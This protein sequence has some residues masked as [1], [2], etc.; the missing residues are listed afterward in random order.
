MTEL[1]NV[2]CQLGIA[3]LRGAAVSLCFA[4]LP[5]VVLADAAEDFYISTI[6]SIV[7]SQCIVC[8]V[9]GG[10]ADAG[11]ADILFTNDAS[12]NHVAF[13]GYVNTPTEGA[14]ADRVLSKITGGSGHG[15]GAVL[16]QASSSYEAIAEYL[17]LLVQGDDPAV[18][19]VLRVFL[20]EPVS[21]EIHAGV[22]NLRGWAVATDGISR[23][24]ILVDG[25]YAFDA[26]Y[27]GARGDV[28]GAFPD[29]EN[30][31][32]S[33]FALAYAYSLLTAGPHTI[34]AVAHTTLGETLESSADFE[35]VKFASDF[36]AD[37]EAVDFSSG[38][39]SLSPREI[40]I[41][42][43]TVEGSLYDVVLKW[44]T[45]AQGFE[46]IEIRP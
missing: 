3:R 43:A 46:F 45:A 5:D 36:I 34:T 19:K 9:A 10:Q 31:D 25:A 14:R 41:V 2:N 24:E 6:E 20:E 38:S 7:Q 42:D 8:H 26:P 44:R 17:E 22:G 1:I 13:K 11:G 33:G 18:N 35:V 32:E 39:C 21:G 23:I 30:S 40:S 37:E 29:V 27:G 16:S 28:G 15:G 4:G 12:A